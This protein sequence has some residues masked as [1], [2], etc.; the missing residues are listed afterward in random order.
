MQR[1]THLLPVFQPC[2][3]KAAVDW[4]WKEISDEVKKQVDAD[5]DCVP[6]LSGFFVFDKITEAFEDVTKED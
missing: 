2:D 4:L 3:I 1:D 5:E 6:M